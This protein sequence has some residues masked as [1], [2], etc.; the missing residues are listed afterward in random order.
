MP[1]KMRHLGKTISLEEAARSSSGPSTDRSHRGPSAPTGERS[2][3]RAGRRLDGRCAAVLACRDGWLR[4]QSRG[5]QRERAARPRERWRIETIRRD[6]FRRTE[7]VGRVR[8]DC[9]GAPMPDGADAVV[10]V[11]ETDIDDRGSVSILPRPLRDRTSAVRVR[12]S[13]QVST[14]SA[15]DAAEREPPRSDRGPRPDGDRGL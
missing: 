1:T 6:R 5:H 11:E 3:A 12:T 13:R 2:R 4:G 9:D 15:R 10:M 14:C 8:R 7:S